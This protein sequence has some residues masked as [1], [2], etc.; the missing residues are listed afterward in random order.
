MSSAE[1]D[2]CNSSPT[3]AEPCKEKN[4]NKKKSQERKCTSKALP[5]KKPVRM[6]FTV[7]FIWWGTF[8]HCT[9]T[10]A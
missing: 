8:L 2:V 6:L 7:S 4:M 9:V 1:E 3:G 5:G 10:E